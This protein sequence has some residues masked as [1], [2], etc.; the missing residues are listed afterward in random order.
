MFKEIKLRRDITFEVFKGKR[1]M[2]LSRRG[3][4]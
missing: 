3:Q 4:V 2:N 1:G